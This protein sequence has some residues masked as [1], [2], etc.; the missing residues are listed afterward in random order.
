MGTDPLSWSELQSGFVLAVIIGAVLLANH[1]GGG[2]GLA[3]KAAQVALG[4]VL[5]MLVFSATAAFHGAPDI[6]LDQL[7][8]M[9]ESEMEL[10]ETTND[11][12][13]RDSE[14]G[15]IHI[16]LGIIFVVLGVVVFRK[17]GAL[18]PGLLLGGILLLLLSGP[19]GGSDQGNALGGLGGL[20]AGIIPGTFGDAGTAR[21]IVRFA[22]LAVG[23]LLLAGVLCCWDRRHPAAATTDALGDVEESQ[24]S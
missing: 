15:S 6:P 2:A 24:D 18:T 14:V 19:E 21:E 3:R 11:A 4:L 13:M 22:V 5:M 1:L 10:V 7:D 20:L 9:F 17:L 23:T 8:S 12:A 16:G